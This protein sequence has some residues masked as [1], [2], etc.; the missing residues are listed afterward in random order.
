MGGLDG[1]RQSIDA[2]NKNILQTG[3][4]D[5]SA[6]GEDGALF[7]TTFIEAMN[8]AVRDTTHDMLDFREKLGALLTDGG[9]NGDGSADAGTD[10]LTS[11]LGGGESARY[12]F[13]TS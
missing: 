9:E 1:L 6:E 3:G 13:T 12:R 8:A 7:D 2:L 10:A 4:T 11:L 5:Q